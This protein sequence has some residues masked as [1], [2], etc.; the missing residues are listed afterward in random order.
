MTLAVITQDAA[1]LPMAIRSIQANCS[2]WQTP[3]ITFVGIIIAQCV[4]LYI[5]RHND[6]RRAD[7]ELIK[8]CTQ[9]SMALGRFKREMARSPSDRDPAYLE[10]LESALY[11]IALMAPTEIDEAATI[12]IHKVNSLLEVEAALL[13]SETKKNIQKYKDAASEVTHYQKAFINVVRDFLGKPEKIY[14]PVDMSYFRRYHN[15]SP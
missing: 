13:K 5:A 2:S 7:P 8:Q 6:K 4:L 12:V 10:D 14:Y 1:I 15:N 9:L 3:T 11:S